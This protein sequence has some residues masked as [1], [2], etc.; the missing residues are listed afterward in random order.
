MNVVAAMLAAG[1]S[2]RLGKPKQLLL[3]PDGSSLVRRS[4]ERLCTSRAR[5][6]AVIVGASATRVVENLVGLSLDIVRSEDYQEG[7]AASIRAAA[8]WATVHEAAALLLCVCDQL[9]LDTAHLNTLLAAWSG[10][11]GLVASHYADKRAVPAIFPAR[12]FPELQSLRG[13][14]G[15]ASIL[16][17]ATHIRLVAWPEGELD[18]DTP[19]DWERATSLSASPRDA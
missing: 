10:D 13:D 19:G 16:Q 1:S 12:Y 18:I 5:R 15:A 8:T 11:H 9:S 3:L 14:I 2:R 17:A 7:I 6:S 4:A